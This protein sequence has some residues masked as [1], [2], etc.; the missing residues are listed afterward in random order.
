MHPVAEFERT[1]Y[2][3]ITEKT[4]QFIVENLHKLGY[5]A[6]SFGP[7][8]P[9]H[10]A[11]QSFVGQQ[12]DAYCKHEPDQSGNIRERWQISRGSATVEIKPLEAK[13]VRKLDMLFGKTL[14]AGSPSAPRQTQA[15]T[16]QPASQEAVLS[17]GTYIDDSDIPF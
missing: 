3:V 12:F 7:L 14:K 2:M 10:A 8:D 13:D 9:S 4:A 11:H 16:T 5:R 6:E 17:D 15:K 1:I